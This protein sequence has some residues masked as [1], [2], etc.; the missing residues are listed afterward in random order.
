MVKTALLILLPLIAAFALSRRRRLAAI[1]GMGLFSLVL[2]GVYLLSHAPDVAI[3]EAAIGAALV[4]FVYVLAIRKTGRLV[5]VGDEVP[6]LLHRERDRLVGLEYEILEG[7]AHHLGLDLVV[8]FLP[9]QEVEEALLRGEGDI[10]AGG[11]V[12]L[13]DDDRFLITPEHLPTALFHISRTGTEVPSPSKCREEGHAGYFSDVLEAVRTGGGRS[14]TLDLAR[15]VAVSR[16]DL[17][18]YTVTRLQGSL[19]YTLLVAADRVTLHHE[20][21]AYVDRLQESKELARI[22]QRYFP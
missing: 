20:L 15:F 5:V 22:T 10:G 19:S 13:R 9:S 21:V 16:L 3:T 17:S 7:F 8:R 4:T 6:G 11:I 2:S 18:E 14:V 12:R 1:I